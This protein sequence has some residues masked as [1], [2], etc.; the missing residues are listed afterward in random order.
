HKSF[1]SQ[2]K[3]FGSQHKSFGSQH[4]SFGSQHKS[5]GSEHKSF[6]SEHKSVLNDLLSSEEPHPQPPTSKATVYTQVIR[7]SKNP[8]KPQRVLSLI[9]LLTKE[10]DWFYVVKP[11]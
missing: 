5:F 4:K 6:G 3:S 1:G 8:L 10:R 11:G 2:H 9:P 7:L